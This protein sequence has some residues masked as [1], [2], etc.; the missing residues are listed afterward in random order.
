MFQKTTLSLFVLL[1]SINYAQNPNIDSIY[2]DAD[3]K[4]TTKENHTYYRVIKELLVNELYDVKD[5]YKSGALQ[6]EGSSISKQ[7]LIKRGD[8]IYYYENGNKKRKEHYDKRLIGN[9]LE[10]YEDGSKKSVGE[11]FQPE[12]GQT[13][14]F[15]LY[16][17]WN[18]DGTQTVINGDGS[19]E[20]NTEKFSESG[21]IKN[22]LKDG[23]WKGEFHKSKS[24]YIENYKNGKLVSGTNTDR[25][26]VQYKYN[27]LESKPEPKK[28]LQDFYQYISKNFKKPKE[29]ETIK[30]KIYVQFIVNKEG[31]IT[32]PIILK[33][34]HPI[35]DQEAIRVISSY[36]KWIPGKVRGLYVKVLYTIP[37]TTL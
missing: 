6:M 1:S 36:S 4:K 35:L 7:D 27:T 15:K 34:L 8:F 25:N 31:E 14:S 20:S 21:N 32:E 18:P 30:G 17:Y 9:C 13:N 12:E 5:Y 22:G 29:L 10:W 11:Y 24:S 23:V 28:G 37:I 26:N 33:S 16:Q 2:Y 19:Y 3:W